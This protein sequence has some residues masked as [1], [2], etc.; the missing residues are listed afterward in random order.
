LNHRPTGGNHEEI[1]MKT[2]HCLA[3]AKLDAHAE[4]TFRAS[5]GRKEEGLS[6]KWTAPPLKRAE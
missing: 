4:G 5:T 3:I 6:G 1:G 2:V